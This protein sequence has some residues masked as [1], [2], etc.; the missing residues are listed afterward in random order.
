MGAP[1]ITRP[2]PRRRTTPAT[3]PRPATKPRQQPR[4]RPVAAV[5]R[6]A[7]AVSGIADS[8]L[9]HRLTRGRAW[10]VVLGL[11]LG[12]IV[13][14]NV[15]GLG[16]SASGSATAA[17]IDDLQRE[18]SVLGGRIANRLSNGTIEATAA[19]L[20]LSIPAADAVHYL[21]GSSSDADRAAE[22]LQNGKITFAPPAGGVPEAVDTTT[23]VEDPAVTQVDPA[24]A[25]PTTVVPVESVDPVDPVEPVAPEPTAVA[26]TE[27]VTTETP[28][29]GAVTP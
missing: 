8:G 17:K 12:G 7:G 18:N 2:A 22:R 24:V 21:D 20:G 10:I 9:V 4:L 5:G 11:M 15:W 26:P 29:S 27:P 19:R 6:T 3:R 13:A 16:M 28:T 14:L 25:D 23:I 1:A